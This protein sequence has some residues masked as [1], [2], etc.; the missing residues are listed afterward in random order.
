MLYFKQNFIKFV[1]L[2]NGNYSPIRPF[3]ILENQSII[4]KIIYAAHHSQHRSFY[5]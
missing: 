1:Q 5:E 4:Q 2:L 3:I